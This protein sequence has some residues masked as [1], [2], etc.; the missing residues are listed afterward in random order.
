MVSFPDQ[1]WAVLERMKETLLTRKIEAKIP[2]WPTGIAPFFPDLE[3]RTK[4]RRTWSRYLPYF[5]LLLWWVSSS[6]SGQEPKYE[7]QR[8]S[9]DD[10]L[11]HP[12]VFSMLRDHQGFLWFGTMNGL[13]KYD[14]YEF[15]TF[16]HE[17]NN[18]NSVSNNNAGNIYLDRAG[19]IWIGS[20][21]GGLDLLDPYTETF[22]RFVPNPNNP[23][24]LN[25]NRVQVIFEDR[26]NTLWVGTAGGGLNRFNRKRGT[27]EHFMH[28]PNDPNSLSF[29]R[30]WCIFQASNGQLFVGT[31]VGL[32]LFHP[33]T[34]T[35]T[36]YPLG[37]AQEQLRCIFE[38]EAGLLW[39]GTRQGLKRFDRAKGTYRDY[40]YRP[41]GSV[42]PH[43]VVNFID[44]G[45]SI[46]GAKGQGRLI[47]GLEEGGVEF[48]LKTERFSP[49]LSDP[50]LS[51]RLRGY[52]LRTMHKDPAD[53][54]WLGTKY[55]GII[56]IDLKQP[57]FKRYRGY[58]SGELFSTRF[59]RV[60][61]LMEDRHK[62]L[63][64]G[65]EGGAVTFDRET[66]RPRIYQH[67]IN[68]P[69]SLSPGFVRSITEDHRGVIWLGTSADTGGLNRYRP[70]HDS[71]QHFRHNPKNP[72]SL[73]DN[74]V[75]SIFE[76]SNH[77]LWIGTYRG[78]NAFDPPRKTFTRYYQNPESPTGISNDYVRAVY[79]DRFKQLWLG[80]NSGGL[81]RFDPETG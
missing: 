16:K 1:I 8:I 76:S 2:K 34:A 32:N 37:E 6:L 42:A 5:T 28:D 46:Y 57:N 55:S 63:W 27:F 52:D 40:A 18:P 65:T 54:L 44:S 20:W 58:A 77:T 22:T 53:V 64:I 81:N 19:H 51:H 72:N 66:K 67:Q 73:S 70:E 41:V 78:L 75:L 80:T 62:N 13:N 49:F 43:Q 15:R 60:R 69:N 7:M 26:A 68:N 47:L 23:K 25:D 36:S 17:P 48:D 74:H 10:G 31:S 79:E 33:E 11:S 56:K 71:F 3:Q 30:V 14:G 50:V 24:A 12:T 9:N 4:N 21:G 29:N 61:S 45:Q 35:F 38:D 59:D 39:V